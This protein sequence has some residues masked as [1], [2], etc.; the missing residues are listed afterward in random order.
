MQ[1]VYN[2]IINC[3]SLEKRNKTKE[4]KSKSN[5]ELCKYIMLPKCVFNSYR[6]SNKMQ[7]CIKILFHIYMKLNMFRETHRPSSRA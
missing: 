3:G 4:G 1:T 6:K 2:Y 5:D 7:N